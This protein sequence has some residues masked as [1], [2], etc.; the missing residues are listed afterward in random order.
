[1]TVSIASCCDPGRKAGKGKIVVGG[2]GFQSEDA[3]VCRR[4]RRSPSSS[5]EAAGTSCWEADLQQG[6]EL[7]ELTCFKATVRLIAS[8]PR[9]ESFRCLATYIS[10]PGSFALPLV[11]CRRQDLGVLGYPTS[12]GGQMSG[13]HD[14]SVG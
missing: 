13:P 10:T 11:G 14:S 2:E 7:A 4:V 5:R 3:D 9:A 1:M 12:A 6:R 8:P